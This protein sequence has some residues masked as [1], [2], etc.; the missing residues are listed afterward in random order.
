MRTVPVSKND[1]RF[2]I[3]GDILCRSAAKPADWYEQWWTGRFARWEPETFRIFDVFLDRSRPY[4]D[5]G[6]WIG[7][8]VLYGSFKASKVVCLEPDPEAHRVLIANLAVNPEIR[9]VTVVQ[10]ALSDRRG[11]CLFGGNGELGN[12]EST[13]LVSDPGYARARG[14]RTRT[15]SPESDA[16]WRDGEKVE[17][18]TLTIDDLIREHGISDC[19]FVKI[20]IEGGE[21]IV[22]PAIREFLQREKPNLYL[23]LH[24]MYLSEDEIAQ[25]VDQLASIYPA[26]Y[27]ESLLRRVDKA[28]TMS[29]RLTSIVCMPSDFSASQ[30]RGLLWSIIRDRV[31]RWLR[32]N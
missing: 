3:D 28:G 2:N 24:W 30:K 32:L 11:T 1:V 27:D 21:R 29:R 10:A 5:V 18:T 20:D 8:T 25:V 12:S 17:V 15:G 9:H 7:P 23:S 19:N 31:L 16:T 22:I 14:S 4:L 26:I 6:A 13:M